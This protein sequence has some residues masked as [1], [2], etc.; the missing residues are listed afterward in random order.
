MTDMNTLYGL[1]SLYEDSHGLFES[2][3]FQSGVRYREMILEAIKII[4]TK[5]RP[6]ILN[7]VESIVWSDKSMMSAIGNSYGDIY[8]THLEWAK[9]SRMNKTDNAIPDGFLENMMPILKAKM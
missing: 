9:N 4:N 5:I 2:G 1:F 8:E 3:Y 7:I 6:S